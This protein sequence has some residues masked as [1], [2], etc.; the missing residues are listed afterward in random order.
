MHIVRCETYQRADTQQVCAFIDMPHVCV[1]GLLVA[2][3]R[4]WTWRG[5]GSKDLEHELDR[6]V[7]QQ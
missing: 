6:H 1:C 2:G 7:M 3:M 5:D 4:A